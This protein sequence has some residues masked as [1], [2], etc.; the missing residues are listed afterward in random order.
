MF[1]T[2]G[3]I[4]RR[5]EDKKRRLYIGFVWSFLANIFVA[6]PIMGAA[7]IINRM[8]ADAAGATSLTPVWGLY[9]LGFMIFA[10]AGRF[11]F[12]YLRATFQESIAYEIS[13]AS[14]IK[15]GNILKR[16][17]LGFFSH[18]STGEIAG[19][20]TTDLSTY[21][22]Y[23][24]KMIDVAVNGYIN[25]AAM[26]LCLAFYSLPIAL[27]AAAG[28]G[29]SAVFLKILG[30]YSHKNVAVHQRAQDDMVSATIE[31]IRG[32]P[33]VKAYGREGV[34]VEAIR[35]SYRDSRD[36][37][38]KLER[39][40]IP[41][42]CLH[43]F[44]LKAAS[45]AIVLTA[46]WLT[47][48]SSL[49][50]PLFMMFAIFSFVIFNHVELINNSTHVMELLESAI[51]KLEGIEQAKFIDTDGRDI[52]LE[53]FDIVF[54]RVTFGYDSREVLTDVSFT[55]PQHSTTAIVGP[56]GSGKTTI[57]SLLARFYD[58]DQGR[59]IIGGHNVREFTCDSL[60]SNIS[61][62]FQNVYLFRD[63]IR[64]N[65][66]FGNPG[67]SEEQMIAAA[68]QARCYDF[69]S[70]LPEGFDTVISEGGASLSGGEKQRISIARAILKDAPVIILDEATASVDPENEHEIQAAITAL[71]R[72]KTII[73][74]AHRLATIEHADQILVVD[75]GQITQ[76]GTHDQLITQTGIYQTYINIR[77]QAE[78]WQIQPD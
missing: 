33:T 3:R 61:M 38:I 26:I 11:L 60:L 48:G 36:I 2:I 73:I 69:I 9:A 52:Q 7:Y 74:I 35:R 41:F 20:V 45:I 5:M 23:A 31:Y 54:D 22:M 65:I 14:R 8:L 42:N 71:T 6:L 39:E 15:I 64:S 78:G 24:M 32:I 13:A 63:T 76:A 16:V 68:K 44:A 4:I 43:L 10:V 56:S 58:V 49:T 17:S 29:L 30:R 25:V 62:V 1:K 18:N 72:G 70:A 77:K 57:C 53:R 46:A 59:I 55:I 47:L 50:V 40:Y 37:N 21:E 67:A 27:I 51:D 34:S 75:Q 28:V 19:A 12:S 66:C